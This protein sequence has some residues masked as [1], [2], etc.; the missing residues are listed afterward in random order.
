MSCQQ[1]GI[2]MDIHHQN[3]TDISPPA[4]TPCVSQ[5]LQLQFRS[6]NIPD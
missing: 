1:D 5:S 6:S 3:F 2:Q 4:Y